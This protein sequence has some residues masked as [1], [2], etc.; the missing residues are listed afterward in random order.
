MV[1]IS[2][3]YKFIYIKN[4][5]TASSTVENFFAKYCCPEGTEILC[6]N[7]PLKHELNTEYGF[8]G[9]DSTRKK[10]N[11]DKL[12][13]LLA[14]HTGSIILKKKFPEEFKEYYKFCVVRNPYQRIVSRFLWD[15]KINIISKDMN[16]KNYIKNESKNPINKMND[17][18]YHRIT[19]NGKLCCNF[20]INFDNLEKDIELVCKKLNI[21]DYNIKELKHINKTETYNYKDYFDIENQK[22]VSEHCYE[23]IKYFDYKI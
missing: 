19:L 9:G 23:E 1:L 3:K 11:N 21:T 16:F 14:Q 4:V 5:K 22:I 7:T 17:D 10:N 8:V 15:K 20:Y 6:K 12:P 2:H 13:G 18:W